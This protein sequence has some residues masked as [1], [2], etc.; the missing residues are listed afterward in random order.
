MIPKLSLCY[1]PKVKGYK[2]GHFANASPILQG[3]QKLTIVSAGDHK[4]S[5]SNHAVNL[6][7]ETH[8]TNS[9]ERAV[10]NLN[11]KTTANGQREFCD[12]YLQLCFGAKASYLFSW[13]HGSVTGFHLRSQTGSE[14]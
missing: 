6:K 9:K 10:V 12:I 11:L 4:C 1:Q 14:H 13:I 5:Y 3:E 7:P 8:Q 2:A